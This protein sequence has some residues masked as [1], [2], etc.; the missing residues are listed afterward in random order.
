MV[1]N[2]IFVRD[3]LFHKPTD[4]SMLMLESTQHKFPTISQIQSISSNYNHE[5]YFRSAMNE[6][7]IFK[8]WTL[9]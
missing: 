8:R 6:L 9:H 1:W 7:P 5:V 3:V 4:M 2:M